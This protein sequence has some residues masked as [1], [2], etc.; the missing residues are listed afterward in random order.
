MRIRF[1]SVLAAALLT[2]FAS[3]G[4]L[5]NPEPAPANDRPDTVVAQ[6]SGATLQAI[7][8]T[9]PA[10][11]VVARAL[12]IVHTAI[13]DAWAAYDGRAIGTELG[14]SLRQVPARRT[15]AN[16]R[17]AV[18]FAAY[19]V[20]VDLFPGEQSVFDD[21]M[22]SLGYDPADP[23]SDARTPAGVGR[24]AANAVLADRH[25]DGSNQLGDLH[26]GAYSDYTGYQPVNAWDQIN[27]PSRWQP[28]RV[29][30]GHGG[31]AI[32]KWATPQWSH[33]KPFA[34]TSADE[35]T[36]SDSAGPAKFGDPR[37]VEQANQ[38][39]GISAN[40]TDREKVIAEYWADGPN[41]ELPPGHWCLFA[42]YVSR[43]DHHTLDQDV[44][45]YFAV[46]NAVL[47]AGISTWTTKIKFDSVRPVTAIHYL[48]AG[49]Q[50]VAWGGPG[51]G[52]QT[53]DGANW[54][55][56][57]AATVVTPPFAEYTSGHSAFSAAA[58]EVLKSF[59]GSDRF[60]ASVTI[61][62]GSSKFEPNVP[63]Q[64]VTLSWKTFSEAADEAGISRRYGGIHFEQGDL[65]SRAIGRKVGAAV[66]QKA[67]SYFRGSHHG[68]D[69]R[70]DDGDAAAPSE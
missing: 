25:H 8:D 46:A 7:R 50:I 2:L 19:T 21:L 38:L 36:P 22:V 66:W 17:E 64:D 29:P 34:L 45:M 4:A 55:P 5:A 16:K 53:I 12:A 49:K 6:W 30:D 62:A 39:I 3:R 68:G 13:Y 44:K 20:L 42:K 59:T 54:Q 14:D 9:K 18:S 43:R 41:S 40:L 51:L 15:P 58:A 11:T 24:L 23:S 27:D 32:Q 61:P 10:P 48:Y 35:F 60:G 56:Y 1:L 70:D 31:F 26:P 63:A 67:L 33:V 52:P 69:G 57:Q 65:D 37:Y 28:L 47:D